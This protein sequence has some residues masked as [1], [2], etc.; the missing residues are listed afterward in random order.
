M[1][2]MSVTLFPHYQSMARSRLSLDLTSLVSWVIAQNLGT[3]LFSI[4]AGWAADRF[5]N[6]RVLNSLMLSLC[7]VPMLALFLSRSQ[8]VDGVWF[9]AV[10]LMLG[11]APVTIRT[12]NNYTLEICGP[13][14]RP[15]YLSTLGLCVATPPMLLSVL[16]GWL[17][18][19][20]SFE[21]VFLVGATCLFSGWCITF[22]LIEPRH[23]SPIQA[24]SASE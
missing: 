18:D 16:M 6:R 15:R 9:N 12:L 22:G 19:Q 4:P 7:V 11:L 21:F 23:S 1:F 24:R 8:T 14:D 5:G 2:G 10:F 3:A 20:I 13:A 17:V